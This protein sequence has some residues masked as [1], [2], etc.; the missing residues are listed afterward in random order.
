MLLSNHFSNFLNSSNINKGQLVVSTFYKF[1]QLNKIDEI[2]ELLHGYL[3]GLNI[4]GTILLAT[5]GING[6]ICCGDEVT[7]RFFK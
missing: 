4:K 7:L 2:K 5:E 1:I 6:T 3:K